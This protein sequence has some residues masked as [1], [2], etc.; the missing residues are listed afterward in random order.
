EPQS[1]LLNWLQKLFKPNSATLHDMTD[2]E[3]RKKI[4]DAIHEM[5]ELRSQGGTFKPPLLQGAPTDD[6]KTFAQVLAQQCDMDCEII[7]KEKIK[8]HLK[9]TD[10][11]NKLDE[12]FNWAQHASKGKVIYFEEAD[13]LL[14]THN[15]QRFPYRHRAR[16]HF[17]T[18]LGDLSTK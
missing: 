14:D 1:G 8:H 15:A 11:I 3:L 17:L 12:L 4:K 13:L 18:K 9:N 10:L 7:S 16:T 2:D 6:Q 5:I